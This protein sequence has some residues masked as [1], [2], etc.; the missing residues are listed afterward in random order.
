MDGGD[1]DLWSVSTRGEY[2]E[3]MAESNVQLGDFDLFGT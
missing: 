1:R 3:E 2:L